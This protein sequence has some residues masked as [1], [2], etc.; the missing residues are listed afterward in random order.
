MY[1]SVEMKQVRKR[2]KL[3][4]GRV[5]REVGETDVINANVTQVAGTSCTLNHHL[6]KRQT[7]IPEGR[8]QLP[9]WKPQHSAWS[10]Q[11][12]GF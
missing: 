9:E 2:K 12:C 8:V 5:T 1:A 10:R 4:C 6:H 11:P 3:T 7:P